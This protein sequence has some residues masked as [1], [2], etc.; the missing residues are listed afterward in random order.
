MGLVLGGL[1]TVFTV[2]WVPL[3][4]LIGYKSGCGWEREF[5][6]LSRCRERDL[7]TEVGVTGKA[8]GDTHEVITSLER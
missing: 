5:K 4:K 1:W 2:L 8:S 6:G 7:E 3:D